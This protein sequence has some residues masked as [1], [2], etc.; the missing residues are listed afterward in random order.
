MAGTVAAVD[1]GYHTKQARYAE[2]CDPADVPSATVTVL[3]ERGDLGRRT[4]RGFCT[5]NADGNRTGV[6]RWTWH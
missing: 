3:V 4:G 1:I 2:T 5:H 6:A